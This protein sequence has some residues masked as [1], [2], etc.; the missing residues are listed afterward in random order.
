MTLDGD[1]SSQA[2]V[3][4][5]SPPSDE[6]EADHHGVAAGTGGSADPIAVL[7]RP[8]LEDALQISSGTLRL[9]LR[10]PVVTREAVIRNF[11]PR[12]ST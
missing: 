6:S 3:A 5:P 12:R 2:G 11:P 4:M 1:T 9:R 10:P 7:D 8:K